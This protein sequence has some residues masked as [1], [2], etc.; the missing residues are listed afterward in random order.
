MAWCLVGLEAERL[1]RAHGRDHDHDPS[2]KVGQIAM[3]V[4]V[5]EIGLFCGHRDGLDEGV[6][7]NDSAL[8]EH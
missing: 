3:L 6:S 5:E 1:W 4:L 7:E 8:R 2:A